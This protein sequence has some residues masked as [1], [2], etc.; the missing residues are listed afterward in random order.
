M[1]VLE[2]TVSTLGS[3]NKITFFY[4]SH[5]RFGYELEKESN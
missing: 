5:T 3:L 4:S 1:V 2:T